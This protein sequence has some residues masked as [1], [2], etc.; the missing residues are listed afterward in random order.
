MLAQ[1]QTVLE[2][3][4]AE[5]AKGATKRA[6]SRQQGG[7][8]AS[9]SNG[10]SGGAGASPAAATSSSLPALP[11]GKYMEFLSFQKALRHVEVRATL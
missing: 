2:V 11:P 1:A 8:A 3:A 5:V 9:D 10:S 7:D 4:E 6:G